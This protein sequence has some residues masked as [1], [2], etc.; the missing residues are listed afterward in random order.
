MNSEFIE[1]IKTL[2]TTLNIPFNTAIELT[3]N[4]GTDLAL[5]Q[6][7]YHQSQ[8]DKIIQATDCDNETASNYYQKYQG[9]IDKVIK[10]IKQIVRHLRIDD[11]IKPIHPSGFILD[12]RKSDFNKI[13]DGTCIFIYNDDF[14][15]V[16]ENF[17]SIFPIKEK[18]GFDNFHRFDYCGVQ[19]FDKDE[20]NQIIDNIQNQSFKNIKE[21]QFS[22]KLIEWINNTLNKDDYLW[23]EGTL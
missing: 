6:K 12:G 18:A 16:V 15:C 17:Q 21:Q 5:C 4:C 14:D 3:K 22:Q 8:L 1:F 9:D 13:G 23:V 2:R 19:I 7:Y 11:S 10:N 20:A